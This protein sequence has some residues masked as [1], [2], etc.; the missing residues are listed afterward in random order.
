MASLNNARSAMRDLIVDMQKNAKPAVRL[1]SIEPTANE[2]YARIVAS[3][4]H[5]GHAVDREA[6][7]STLCDL[8]NRKARPVHDSFITVS[9][10]SVEDVI[11]GVINSNPEIIVVDDAME[12]YRAV[13]GNM[14]MDD[15][16]QLWALR[17]TEGGKCLIKARGHEDADVIGELVASLSSNVAR[18][19]TTGFQSLS[20]VQ[21]E[22]Q[23]RHAIDGGD[24]VAFVNPDTAS[25]EMGAVVASVTD[26]DNNDLGLVVLSRADA[27]DVRIDRSLVVAQFQDVQIEDADVDMES[28]SANVHSIEEIM[29]YYQQMFSR[30]P[31]YF[32]MFMA[33]WNAHRF[34]G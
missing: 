10:N 19:G 5:G 12:G 6:V 4:A 22:E 7:A 29:S 2:G 27:R 13:A 32:D 17:V 11:T 18:Y 8:M 31:E 34:F 33:R 24:F 25:V 1:L 9:S 28:L 15:E 16:E 26:E 21:A 20:S 3:I 30:R 23:A 14:F